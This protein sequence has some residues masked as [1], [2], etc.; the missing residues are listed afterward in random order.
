MA[1]EKEAKC[2]CKGECVCPRK[3]VIGSLVTKRGI[4]ETGETVQIEEISGGV[5]SWAHLVEKGFIK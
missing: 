5:A 2:A 4:R 1:K 3:V